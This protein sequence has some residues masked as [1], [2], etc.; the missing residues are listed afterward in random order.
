[1]I[2]AENRWKEQ[3]LLSLNKDFRSIKQKFLE[4]KTSYEQ[5]LI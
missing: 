1:M 5:A 2:E 4:E 3:N